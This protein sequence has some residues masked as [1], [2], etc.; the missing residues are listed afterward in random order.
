MIFT[1]IY[2]RRCYQ[3]ILFMADEIEE[4]FDMVDSEII[5]RRFY[6]VLRVILQE[7]TSIRFIFCGADHLTDILYNHALAD[8]FEITKRVIISRLDEDSMRR[9][10][11]EPA[12]DKLSYTDLAIERIWYYTK[13]HTFYSKHICSKVIDILN[14]ESRATAY[15]YD[16]DM[17]VKQVM[18]VTE[19]FIYLTR[20]FSEYDKQVIR[21]ICENTKF[22][23]DRVSED[24]LEDN[25][26]GR[27]LSDSLNSL[28]FKDIL[29]KTEGFDTDFYNFS[30]EMFRLWYSKT[31]F[32]S[33]G[34]EEDK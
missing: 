5:N 4:I 25:Y 21:I 7:L 27:G 29:E 26:K 13:G 11:T 9:M 19:Y 32:M 30:I 2:K 18:R 24:V 34:Y 12:T 16:I 6:K 22:A 23:K 20:F 28:E 10:I 33:T 14:E 17:A 8:V 31:E 3:V 15:A 1:H